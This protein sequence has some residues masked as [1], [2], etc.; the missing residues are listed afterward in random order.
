MYLRFEFVNEYKIVLNGKSFY[1]LRLLEL[2]NLLGVDDK[3][4]KEI[5]KEE[6][7]LKFFYYIFR[8]FVIR[9]E[10]VIFNWILL[11][12]DLG[13]VFNNGFLDFVVNYDDGIKLGIDVVLIN[14]DR[15]LVMI[16]MRLRDRFYRVYYEI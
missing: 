6:R 5:V 11:R 15:N 13:I 16:V 3:I 10:N 2:L 7:Y 14:S 4:V 12:D 8:E 9:V 1:I